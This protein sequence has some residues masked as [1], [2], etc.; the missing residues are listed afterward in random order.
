M[1]HC[2]SSDYFFL[3]LRLVEVF[4]AVPFDCLLLSFG[5]ATLLSSSSISMASSSPSSSVP[6]SSEALPLWPP[7]G[8]D[9][10]A[11]RELRVPFTVRVLR[12]DGVPR[13]DTG[14]ERGSKLCVSDWI[15]TSA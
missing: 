1:Y 9:T 15:C 14:E 2:S 13:P 12:P 8:T 6:G 5:A 7:P 10:S 3:P 11:K 4:V